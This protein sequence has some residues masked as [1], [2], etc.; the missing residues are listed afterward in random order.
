MVGSTR[1]TSNG[2]IDSSGRNKPPPP[3]DATSI[4]AQNEMMRHI[5]LHLQQQ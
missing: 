1:N 4:A 2:F 5:L 3:L